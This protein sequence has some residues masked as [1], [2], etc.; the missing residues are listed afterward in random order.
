LTRQALADGLLDMLLL[1]RA[2]LRRPEASR[3]QGLIAT[4]TER[5]EAAL[6]RCETDAAAHAPAA[7][8]IGDIAV[9]VLLDYLDF[10][11][12]ELG[13]RATRPALTE[14]RKRLAERASFRATQF[15]AAWTTAPG[16][17]VGA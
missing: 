1:W 3:Q 4:W 12:P 10:R 9:G 15:C 7:P 17:N 5:R 2:E 13:W 8:D 16:E 6:D 14:W 11:F